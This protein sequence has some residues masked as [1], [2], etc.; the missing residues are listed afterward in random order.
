MSLYKIIFFFILFLSSLSWSQEQVIAKKSS[1]IQSYG[2]SYVSWF[3]K[4]T[5]RQSGSLVQNSQAIFNGLKIHYE[6][7]YPKRWSSRFGAFAILGQAQGGN[8]N[9]TTI[10]YIAAN[11][12]CWGIGGLYHY[13]YRGSSQT[14]MSLGPIV[15]YR[16]INWPMPTNTNVISGNDFNLGV[17]FDIKMQIS[18][19]VSIQHSIGS[20][21]IDATSFWQLGLNINL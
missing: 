4:M 20:L 12:P 15:M 13:A 8:T 1:T 16:N 11:Q 10:P 7:D 5:I 17:T 3:E 2:I 18:R 14:L 9:H 6:F 19:K 21:F